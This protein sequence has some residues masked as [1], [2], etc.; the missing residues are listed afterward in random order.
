MFE[1]SRGGRAMTPEEE[2]AR[3]RAEDLATWARQPSRPT[4]PGFPVHQMGPDGKRK[5]RYPPRKERSDEP[6]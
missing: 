6:A 1:V 4:G 3:K 5:A 2:E